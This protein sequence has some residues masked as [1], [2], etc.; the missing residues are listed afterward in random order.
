[1]RGTQNHRGCALEGLREELTQ[2]WRP[3]AEKRRKILWTDMGQCGRCPY[4][5]EDLFGKSF[6][7]RM[8]SSSNHVGS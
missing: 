8:M 2:R 1:M 6:L 4:K 7:S 3:R 5:P